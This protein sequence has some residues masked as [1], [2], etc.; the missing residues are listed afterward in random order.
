[1]ERNASSPPQLS[2]VLPC[3]NEERRIGASLDVIA[4]WLAASDF[5]AEVVVVDDGSRDATSAVAESRRARLPGLVVLRCEQNGGKGRAVKTGVLAARAALVLFSDADL[6]TPIE[7]ALQLTARLEAGA[8]MAIGSRR[9]ARSRIEVAQ[10]PLRRLLGATFVTLQKLIVGTGFSDTQ[11]GFK[12]FRREVATDLF[13]RSLIPGYC[14]DVELLALAVRSGYRVEEVPLRWRD[15]RDSQIH[16]VRDSL[17]MLAD[18]F[19]IRW[20]LLT[21]KYGPPGRS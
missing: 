16:V 20:N 18:M 9:L 1:M 15:D 19:R 11:C 12:A 2:I 5:N 4:D 6:S 8:D 10:S 14:F 7:E 17:R 13:G 3:F 21:G